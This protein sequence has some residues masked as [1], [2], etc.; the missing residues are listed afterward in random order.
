MIGKEK[1]FKWPRNFV[2]WKSRKA[3]TVQECL[4]LIKVL[5]HRDNMGLLDFLWIPRKNMVYRSATWGSRHG[6]TRG[7]AQ[8][9]YKIRDTSSNQS[10]VY[11]RINGKDHTG[12]FK[13]VGGYCTLGI[14]NWLQLSKLYKT[15][16]SNV[17]F[18]KRDLGTQTSRMYGTSRIH[19]YE[20]T[21][22]VLDISK[23]VSE[24]VP[25]KAVSRVVH[26][27]IVR[28]RG[29]A[30]V[31][32]PKGILVVAGRHRLFL[33]PGGGANRGENREKATGRELREETGLKAI[34]SKYLFTYEEPEDNRIR[35]LHKV[36]LI[37]ANGNLKPDHHEVK[38]I[39]YWKPSSNLRLSSDTKVIIDK[40]IKEF[41]K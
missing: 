29:T 10:K 28:R 34:S 39:E 8:G 37:K 36:F 26:N 19:N 31:D 24:P 13:I 27:Q 14:G 12:S 4:K 20:F 17:K 15:P 33:L 9:H 35:N 41:K 23:L 38:Y 1:H 7:E 3:P 21:A 5:F 25:S 32:T 2:D 22:E 11:V 16:T 18:R 40:Y 6:S 30:I